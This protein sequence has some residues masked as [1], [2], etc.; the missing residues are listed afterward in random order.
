MEELF[1]KV[2]HLERVVESL[3]QGCIK[4][5]EELDQIRHELDPL[6]QEVFRQGLNKL[7]PDQVPTSD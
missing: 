4:L 1:K 7:T 6:R 5:S 3:R 2:T